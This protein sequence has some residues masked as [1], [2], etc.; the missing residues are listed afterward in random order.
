MGNTRQRHNKTRPP[1]GNSLFEPCGG[2]E[3]QK[4]KRCILDVDERSKINVE[5]I[6]ALLKNPV[7]VVG[8]AAIL[9]ALT[10]QFFAG[11]AVA[12]VISALCAVIAFVVGYRLG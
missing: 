7:C 6:R 10:A 5:M 1:M 12:V 2:P 9:I 8:L 11:F 3:G 4:K